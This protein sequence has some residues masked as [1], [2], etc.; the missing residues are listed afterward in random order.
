[1]SGDVVDRVDAEIVSEYFGM[2][3][4]NVPEDAD[5]LT[6][7][8]WQCAFGD[9]EPMPESVEVRGELLAAVI[10]WKL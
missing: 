4:Q 6:A 1:M 8:M 10:G 5:V 3:V 9:G 2:P 7:A